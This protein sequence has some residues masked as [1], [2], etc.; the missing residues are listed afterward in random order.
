MSVDFY[1]LNAGAFF[2]RSVNADMGPLHERFLADVPPGGAIL[3]AGCG[4]GRDARAFTIAGYNVTAFDGS[5]AM[6][7]MASAHTGLR[8]LHMTFDEVEWS[9]AFDGVWACASLLHVATVA[10]PATA[11][12]LTRA[13]RPGGILFASFKDGDSERELGGRRFTDLRPSAVQSLLV[14][15]GLQVLDVWSAADVRPDRPDE[16]W[17]SAIAR[18]PLQ[19]R[20]GV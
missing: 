8:V 1:D 3:D 6:V 5:A 18:K 2:Q 20:V 19:A 9:G 11:A 17:V 12:R 13:L 15:A 14:G 10:L 4:S 16:M 7:R